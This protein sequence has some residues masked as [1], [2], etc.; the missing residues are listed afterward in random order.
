MDIVPLDQEISSQ[1]LFFC[2]D[3]FYKRYQWNDSKFHS[4]IQACAV[5][6]LLWPAIGRGCGCFFRSSL[7]DFAGSWP[8]FRAAGLD[9]RLSQTGEVLDRIHADLFN[10][11]PKPWELKEYYLISSKRNYSEI[12]SK[13]IDS[14]TGKKLV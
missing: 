6:N 5:V 14:A 13:I 9:L 7:W 8:I 12:K 1:T 4:L 10:R 11:Q 3:N 2:N